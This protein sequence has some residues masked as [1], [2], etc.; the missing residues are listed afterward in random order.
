MNNVKSIIASTIGNKEHGDFWEVHLLPKG[1]PW[2]LI[3][4]LGPLLAALIVN[5]AWLFALLIVSLVPMAVLIVRYPFAAIMIWVVVMPWFPFRGMYKYVYFAFHRLLIPL[6]LGVVLLSR[7]LRLKK[8]SPVQLGPAELAM[9]AFGAMGFISIFVTGNDWKLI[10]AL[11]DR[12]LVPFMAYWL[13]QFSNSQEQDL[14]RLIPLMSLLTLAE[15]VVALVSWFAPQ[16]LPSIWRSG[17]IG[18]RVMGTF[19]QPIAYGCVLLSCLV[20]IYHD[21]MNRGKG[22]TR[23]LHMLTFGLGMVC[24]FFT[25]T[26]GVWLGGI[27]VLLALLYLYPKPTTLL[28]AVL[29]PVMVILLSGVLTHEFAHAYERLNETEEGANARAVLANAGKNMFY[30]RP[31]FGWGFGNYD[32]YDWKF[33]ERVRDTNPTEWQIRKGTSHSTFLTVLAEMGVVG[34]FLLYFPVI[35]WLL[36]TI[37]ALPRLPKEGFWSRRLLI[38]MW[39]PIGVQLVLW[40]DIDLRFF[41]YSVTLFWINLGFIA[42]AVRTCLQPSGFRSV[43]QVMPSQTANL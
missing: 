22:S 19:G 29:V 30:A 25:F 18:E 21:A 41:Y 27:L 34:F 35:W 5:E 4:G 32:R 26:R 10:F 40:Q 8:R 39:V 1:L 43:G 7:M 3:L 36:F 16:A 15:C 23:R 17:L 33:M 6:A 24:I 9:V 31:V 2:L 13:I 12:F 42:N 14:R 20:F 28:L 11:E 38:A 37:K